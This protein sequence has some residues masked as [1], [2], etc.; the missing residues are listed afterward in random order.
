MVGISLCLI[1]KNEEPFLRRT[2]ELAASKCHDLVIIDTGSTDATL[3]IA[4]EFTSK[5]AHS[6]GKSWSESRNEAIDLASEAWILFLDADEEFPDTEWPEIDK[7]L[8]DTDI[9]VSA[10][11]V[12]RYNFSGRGEVW[13]DRVVRFFR[14]DPQIRYRRLV[15][16]SVEDSIAEI[17][18][19]INDTQIILNHWGSFRTQ[20]IRSAKL[21]QYYELANMQVTDYPHTGL[22]AGYSGFLARVVGDWGN[23]ESWIDLALQREAESP[24][25]QAYRGHVLRALGKNT[26]ALS[27]FLQAQYADPSEDSHTNMVGVMKFM[28]GDFEGARQTFQ[29]IREKNPKFLLSLLNLGLLNQAEENYQGAEYLFKE[30][31][32]LNSGF[33]FQDFRSRLEVDHFTYLFNETVPHFAG[34]PYHLGYCKIMLEAGGRELRPQFPRGQGYFESL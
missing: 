18:G 34:L 29:F 7:A 21:S 12:S 2:L 19:T 4:K 22:W 28:L 13:M 23:A 8:S 9:S 1:V 17:N 10:L 5:I 32:L 30:V 31:A 6:N 15:G 27:A 25:V 16:E 20:R 26:E 33:M 3:S 14:N 11:R 24:R